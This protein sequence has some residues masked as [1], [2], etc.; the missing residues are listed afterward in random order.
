MIKRTVFF[1]VVIATLVMIPSRAYATNS[2]LTQQILPTDCT[3]T[4]VTSEDGQQVVGACPVEAPIVTSVETSASGQRVVR[5]LFDAARTT[6]LKVT[7]R[8]V[9]YVAGI[10]NSP[11]RTAGDSWT[12][13]I[14]EASPDTP[15][16]NYLLEV[17]ALLIDGR[18]LSASAD[19]NLPAEEEVNPDTGFNPSAPNGVSADELGPSNYLLYGLSPIDIISS[20]G[21]SYA[22]LTDNSIGRPIAAALITEYGRGAILVVTVGII[23]FG[24]YLIGSAINYIRTRR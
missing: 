2:Q 8:G 3:L 6:L 16:G 18:I 13:S 11:L 22:Y 15:A 17:E 12:F 19:F 5:G 1:V 21:Y 7:F 24:N 14:D 23:V 9:E 4:V 20:G 10:P